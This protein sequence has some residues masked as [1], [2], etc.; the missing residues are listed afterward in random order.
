[1][2]APLVND[3]DD[4]SH[5]SNNKSIRAQVVR[6]EALCKITYWICGG[7]G[8]VT[9]TWEAVS[10]PHPTLTGVPSELISSSTM[11]KSCGGN[12]KRFGATANDW[13]PCVSDGYLALSFVRLHKPKS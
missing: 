5:N 7:G 10:L 3:R 1:M 9:A 4:N 13:C 12:R 6:S 11:G 2:V 8:W